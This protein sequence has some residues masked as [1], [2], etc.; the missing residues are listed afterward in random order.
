M[1]S[2]HNYNNNLRHSATPL[3]FLDLN[4]VHNAPVNMKR[5]SNRL[6]TARQSL[7]GAPR[8]SISNAN[9]ANNNNSNNINSQS[10]SSNSGLS[11]KLQQSAARSSLTNN[12]GSSNV[13]N[14]NNRRKSL[15]NS[16]IQR[17]NNRTSS[18]GINQ[19]KDT[20]PLR[21]K[22]FQATMQQEIFNFLSFNNFENEMR[23]PISLRSLK[24][25]TQKDFVLIFQFLYK[26]I[27]P[28][29]KFTKSFEHEVYFVLKNIK[30]PWLETINKSQISA[31]GGQSWP[32]FLGVLYWLIQLIDKINQI[33]NFDDLFNSNNLILDENDEN[34]IIEDDD[35]NEL[36]LEKIFIKYIIK[37]YND[38]LNNID[39]YSEHHLEM[40]KEYERY[41]QDIVV[42]TQA[43]EAEN[44]DLKEKYEKLLAE[45]ESLNLIE[46]KAD[47]LEK[48]LF[49]FKQYIDSMDNRKQKWGTILQQIE[50]EIKNSEN[51][52]NSINEE[53]T[54]LNNQMVEL[55]IIPEEIDKMNLERDKISKQIDLVNEKLAEINKVVSLKEQEASELN[56]SLINNL[57]EFNLSIYTIFSNTNEIKFDLS[58]LLI[59]FENENNF[60]NEENLGKLPN[61]LLNNQDLNTNIKNKLFE[62]KN[63]I[64]SRIH[65]LQD[66]S[67]NLQEAIELINESINEKLEVIDSLETEL[68]TK[69]INYDELYEN[70]I[71]D[72]NS[73]NLEIEKFENELKILKLNSKQNLLLLNQQSKTI[74]MEYKKF[75][76]DIQQQRELLHSKAQRMMERV[77]NL[78]LNIQASLEDIENMV[79]EELEQQQ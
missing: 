35:K 4:Q 74:E 26:R 12:I 16:N 18:F 65:K 44:V 32:V 39:D 6:S 78:K 47:V 58:K 64:N 50:Q 70:M 20:R 62:L 36:E 17:S 46:K 48:D 63:E 28:G 55:N 52:L 72:S 8:T 15:I 23:H 38:F 60:L 51:E 56:E 3:S 31:V 71:K 11:E 76:N 61:D 66:E 42:K 40:Q 22:N 68:S 25:P 14:N 45:A 5:N 29:Y 1:S 54:T 41:T 75:F 21:D 30:Y 9:H 7:I 73:N 59:K 13:N 10:R 37:S 34:S 49:K 43:M 69:K 53:K 33:T 67:I 19:T 27:D 2:N 57:K 77:I 79:I 24:A